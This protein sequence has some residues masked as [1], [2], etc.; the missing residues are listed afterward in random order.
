MHYSPW[1]YFVDSILRAPTIGCM[2]MCFSAALVGVIAFLRKESLLGEA[3][4]HSS[5]PGVILGVVLGA[6]LITG[7]S[8]W[9]LVPLLSM[10]GAFFTAL[11]GLY[12]IHFL[13]RRLNIRPDS[14][15]CFILSAFF[16]I[17]ITMAS[18]VQFSHTALYKQ[19]L[20]YL[21]GQAATMTDIHIILY[22]ALATLIVAMVLFFY[23]ELKVLTFD[24]DYAESLGIRVHLLDTIVFVL[25][26]MA[27]VVGIRSV[28]VVLM[29]AM[30]IAPAVAARQFT[31]RLSWMLALAGLFGLI[32]GYL[33]NVLSVELTYV[34]KKIYPQDRIALP[35][36]PMIV[37]VI[38]GICMIALL[39]APERGLIVRV[40]RAAYFR[41]QCLSENL[42]KGM[43]RADQEMSLE[44]F[45]KAHP[46]SYAYLYFVMWRLKRHGWV[47]KTKSGAYRLT[48]DGVHRGAHIVRL[49]RLWEVYLADYL[50]VGAE[51][52]HK[53]A[54]EME[55]II[56]PELEREL[57]LLLKD[58]KMD[59]HH[60]PIPPYEGA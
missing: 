58:P 41:Y 51:R 34:L 36:G 4:S 40:L 22:G 16:G 19:S 57:T 50:G 35:T 49:H 39:F 60:Q 14:A 24:R 55:H 13:E 59:P 44:D 2:L 1:I 6:G 33:G 11:L 53:S 7:Y 28:G 23:K 54:E 18:R 30:L 56:T 52:V 21:Y 47:E 3:L 12:C 37:M 10:V 29:S 17:G 9:L 5:Y 15:L 20:S 8:D 38:T 32:S 27:I 42:L 45:K 25:F 31:H 48:S 43:W 26:A 46:V